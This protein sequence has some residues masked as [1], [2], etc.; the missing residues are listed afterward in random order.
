M[1]LGVDDG[2]QV[3]VVSKGPT[4]SMVSPTPGGPMNNT[5]VASSTKRSVASTAMSLGSTLGWVAKS[6]SA[7]VNG[8]GSEA[9]RAR[10]ALR[11]SSTASTS[12]ARSRSI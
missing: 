11:R 7:N 8:E 2:P 4:A 5:L 9:K 12:T 10:L 6:K 3:V 1:G